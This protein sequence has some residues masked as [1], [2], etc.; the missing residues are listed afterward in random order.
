[1]GVTPVCKS[2]SE[3]QNGNIFGVKRVTTAAARW[4]AKTFPLREIPSI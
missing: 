4:N 2:P 3:F 1:V